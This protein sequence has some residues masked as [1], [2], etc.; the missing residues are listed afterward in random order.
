RNEISQEQPIA[1][2][3]TDFIFP[4]EITGA[5]NNIRI[6]YEPVLRFDGV[7]TEA[8]RTALLTDPLLRTVS[9][10]RPYEQAIEELFRQSGQVIV[11]GLPTGFSFPVE[12]TGAP[13]NIPI[14]YEPVLRFDGVMTEPERKT[15]LSDPSLVAVTGMIPYQEAIETLFV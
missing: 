15:L 11:T 10:L 1:T 14:Y 4:T 6:R 7:M 12:I 2:L 5:P 9:R 13:N 8:Q 3:P